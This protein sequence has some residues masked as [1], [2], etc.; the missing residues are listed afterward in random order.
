MGMRHADERLSSI[1]YPDSG[2]RVRG[3]NSPTWDRG[4]SLLGLKVQALFPLLFLQD[5]K[6][7]FQVVGLLMSSLLIVVG[8]GPNLTSHPNIYLSKSL[9]IN[10]EILFAEQYKT[11]MPDKTQT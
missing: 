11:D 9:F 4:R 6:D 8:R 3:P 5:R 2:I 1:L 10:P 7:P